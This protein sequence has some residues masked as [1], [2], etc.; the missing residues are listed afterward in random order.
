M[1]RILL[2]HGAGGRE[3]AALID[4]VFLAR[5]GD[6]NRVGDDSATVVLGS[7]RLAFTTD[8]FVVDPLFFPGGDIGRLAVA[9]T[10]ND[11]LTAA[12]RP[13][14]LSASFILEEGLEISVL[15]VIAE[16][17]RVTASEAGV[18][19]V[20]G[21][22]KVVPKGSADQVFITTAGV[23]LVLRPGVSG[24]AALQGDEIILTGS[25]GDHGMAVLLAREKLLDGEAIASDAAPLTGL[26]LNLLEGGCKIHAMRDPT[27]GGIASA[28]N[29]IARQSQV[30]MEIIETRV[31][32]APAV[33]AAC[34]ALGLDVFQ[35]ANEGKM[36]IIV[37]P[38]DAAKALFIIRRSP[39]GEAARVIG[40]VGAGPAG[41]VQVRT[42]IG[43]ARLLDPPSG[44]LLPRIC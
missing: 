8:S 19:I 12:A 9:G 13:L 18:A 32:V 6:P 4:E 42:V 44:D 29:E 28:L 26:V 39:Y 3:M 43:T 31:P 20:T 40:K 23:G 34:E 27:R 7:H 21:D 30:A 11:L 33:A 22:T 1:S 5:Y 15:Q 36:L 17:M 24:A 41:R 14:M 38:E 16:S 10:V 37:A 25:V 35:V 2:S